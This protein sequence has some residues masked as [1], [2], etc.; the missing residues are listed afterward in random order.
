MHPR[1]K[2]G[3]LSLIEL[4]TAIAVMVILVGV[5]THN[6]QGLIER[7]QGRALKTQ[8]RTAFQLARYQSIQNRQIVTLCP[9]NSEGHCIAQWN[10]PISVFLDPDNQKKLT[11]ADQLLRT[12]PESKKGNL[13]ASNSG[14][15][16]RRY[17]QFTPQGSVHGTIG[18]LTWCPN[19]GDT[20]RGFQLVINFGGRIRWARDTDNDGVVETASGDPIVCV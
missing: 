6:W 5:A 13:V 17:F 3:G 20:Q 8:L 9:L 15:Y 14:I 18:N 12:I 19:S 4:M 1:K 10:Q 2:E 7:Q 16:Q 11:S